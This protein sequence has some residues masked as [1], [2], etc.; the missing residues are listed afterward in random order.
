MRYI[1]EGQH[2]LEVYPD[3]RKHTIMYFYSSMLEPHEVNNLIEY[4]NLHLAKVENE[5]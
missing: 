2:L 5:G 3:G 4:A 1:R